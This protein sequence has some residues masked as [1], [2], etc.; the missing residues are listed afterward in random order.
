MTPEDPLM[1][2]DALRHQADYAP[3]PVSVG[4]TLT[5]LRKGLFAKAGPS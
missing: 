3:E 4:E 5:A 2:A 1:R